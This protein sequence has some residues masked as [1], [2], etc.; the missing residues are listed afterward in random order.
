LLQV[1]V[2]DEIMLHLHN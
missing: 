2:Q 1:D